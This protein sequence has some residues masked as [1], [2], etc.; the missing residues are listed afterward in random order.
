MNFHTVRGLSSRSH[1]LF[2]AR[3]V[4]AVRQSALVAVSALGM[5]YGG[6]AMAQDK[7]FGEVFLFAGSYCPHGSVEASGQLLLIK[8]NT[9]LFSLMGTRYGGD[10]RTNF[11]LP[12]LRGRSPIGIG[13]GPDLAEITLGQKSGKEKVVLTRDN[14]PV[15]NHFI[16]A[17]D[18]VASTKPATH[19]EPG[20]DRIPAK[21]MNAGGYIAASDANTTLGPAIISNTGSTGNNLPVDIRNPSLGMTWC[22]AVSGVYP[23]RPSPG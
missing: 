15:H 13:E 16:A 19:T 3:S 9:I 4:R 8:E 6:Q 5:L 23:S 21:T 14:L 20:P 2:F 1:P 22:V 11:A 18:T 17:T 10:G 12:D 7:Y